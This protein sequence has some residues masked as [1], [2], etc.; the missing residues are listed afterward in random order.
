ML[1]GYNLPRDWTYGIASGAW[2][3]D[4]AALHDRSPAQA[5]QFEWPTGA[6]TTATTV[7]VTG[8]RS[9]AVVPRLGALLGTTLPAGLRVTITGRRSGDAGYTYDL[10]GNSTTLRLS[11]LPDGTVGGVWVFADGLDPI[12][13]WRITAY[14]DVSGATAIAAESER[15][16]G[17][18]VVCP[19]LYVPHE[20][21][22][23]E[24][25]TVPSIL[26]RFR[27]AQ[28]QLVPHVPF[29]VIS[30]RGWPDEHVNA[31]LGGLP[32]GMD[33]Q[34]LLGALARDP[35]TLLV[36]YWDTSDEIQRSAVFGVAS[37][38]GIG[39]REGRYQQMDKLTVAEIP[40]LVE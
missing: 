40:A 21:G 10:G 22:L 4:P 33:W 14:N 26:R 5:V 28:T 35:Y 25:W 32:G 27:S 1:I 18:V 17:E 37:G 23:Q 6:Q 31:R 8:T 38:F 20:D 34:R 30:L 19:A 15:L 2:L 7:Q 11:V 12:V 24:T 39:G 36:P 9:A 3:T 29:R 16:L 13:A